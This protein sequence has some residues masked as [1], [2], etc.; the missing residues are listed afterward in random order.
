[1][2]DELKKW[3]LNII[4]KEFRCRLTFKDGTE[5][6]GIPTSLEHD[7]KWTLRSFNTLEDENEILS[8]FSLEELI[9]IETIE[10]EFDGIL[11]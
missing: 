1:M 7:I 9:K 5:A 10:S 3:I 4:K 6:V 8:T 2:K 11:H